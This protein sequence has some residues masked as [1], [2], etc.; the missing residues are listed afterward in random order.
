MTALLPGIRVGLRTPTTPFTSPF[1]EPPFA[2]GGVIGVSE[3]GNTVYVMWDSAKPGVVVKQ[4]DQHR[5][6]DL[7]ILS[8]DA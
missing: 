3:D 2:V 4:F 6:D 1:V 7:M 5:P 8:G